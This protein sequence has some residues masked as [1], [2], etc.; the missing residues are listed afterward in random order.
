M[1]GS[2][3]RGGRLT[4]Q[5]AGQ[6]FAIEYHAL[7]IRRAGEI[8]QGGHEVDGGKDGGAVHMIVFGNHTRPPGNERGSYAAFVQVRLKA[9]ERAS[10]TGALLRAVVGANE[11]ECVVVKRGITPN[12]IEEFAEL[13]IH[14]LQ[15]GVVQAA[16]AIGPF[17]HRR[18]KRTVNIIRPE[19]N[20][21]RFLRLHGFLNKWNR[22]VHKAG[23]DFRSQHPARALAKPLGI[24]PDAARFPPTR[25]ERERQQLRP[26]T[27]EVCE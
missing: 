8:Q 15:H 27:L 12:K 6:R 13:A 11:H 23:G 16:L 14:L 2:L 10:G 7:G 4:K 17:V 21:E 5:R 22:L 18:P 24:G 3:A 1:D 20:I 9:A 26:H 19:I 25:F